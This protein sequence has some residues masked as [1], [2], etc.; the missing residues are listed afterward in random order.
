MC[1]RLTHTLRVWF[2]LSAVTDQPSRKSLKRRRVPLSKTKRRSRGCG[3]NHHTLHG[4][5]KRRW[6]F[7][8][9]STDRLFRWN[10]GETFVA[11]VGRCT[12]YCPSVPY[13]GFLIARA[14][15]VIV[16]SAAF[17]LLPGTVLFVKLSKLNL[18]RQITQKRG[19][20]CS[21]S[22]CFQ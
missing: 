16:V 15:A 14:V 1:Q 8:N 6:L 11:C 7:V 10:T 3:G 17:L 21:G 12:V 2:A 18:R 9:S 22:K 20:L 19:R 4:R 5:V 13:P